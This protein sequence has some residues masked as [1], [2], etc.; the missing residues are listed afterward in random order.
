MNRGPRRI[1]YAAPLWIAALATSALVG[2]EDGGGIVRLQIQAAYEPASLEF[3]E[4]PLEMARTLPVALKNTGSVA[5]TI[6]AVE[7]TPPY[8]LS[9]LKGPL[10]EIVVQAGESLPLEVRYFPTEE[11]EHAAELVVRS[12]EAVVSLPLHGLGVLRR[13]PVMSLEPE[14]LNFGA[15]EVGGTARATVTIRNTGN[16]PGTIDRASLVSTGADVRPADE[17]TVSTPLPVQIPEGGAQQL[18]IVFS[19]QTEGPRADQ[20]LFGTGGV[21]APLTLNLSGEGRIPF[22][23]VLCTPSSVDFGPVERSLVET[24]QVTCTARGGPARIIGATIT[25]STNLFALAAPQPTL[26]LMTDESTVIEVQFRPDGLPD[27]HSATLVVNYSGGNGAASVSVPL[28]GEVV[29]PPPSLTALSIVLDWDT[30]DTDVDLHL[31]KVPGSLFDR[32]GR[33][34]CYFGQR[35]PDWGVQGDTSDDP[36]LDHDDTDG[37]GPENINLS[38]SGDGTY[39]VY[40]HYWSDHGRGRTGA[41]AQIFIDGNPAGTFMRT[42]LDCDDVWLVGTAVFTNGNGMF[43]PANTVT[44]SNRGAC[45]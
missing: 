2:C 27:T 28:N 34:D 18:E 10:E 11:G 38:V 7:I 20:M 15:V 36:F 43:M 31:V 24:A 3:G 37:F 4:V 23:E 1:G 29:P 9:G 6:S 26:D 25:P 35:T 33:T 22:G 44:P 42:N 30:N 45:F 39:E 17:F 5:F 16:A 32:A 21:T 40:V 12:G 13:V 41:Q 19:P 8:S 14:N